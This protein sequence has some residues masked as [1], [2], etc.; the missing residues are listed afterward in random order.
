M[1][2][3]LWIIS[4]Y[5]CVLVLQLQRH[6]TEFPSHLKGWI[7]K[8][9]SFQNAEG[10]PSVWLICLSFCISLSREGK[11]TYSP[12]LWL[13]RV[14]FCCGYMASQLI[15]PRICLWWTFTHQ[16][17]CGIKEG[18]L[19]YSQIRWENDPSLTCQIGTKHPFRKLL[20]P[21]MGKVIIIIFGLKDE[22]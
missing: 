18:I 8:S 22:C 20:S 10:T 17:S 14:W 6:W 21:S 19:Y 1:T 4:G 15:P 7:I 16:S 11:V 2:T 13:G 12:S 5:P 9:C 3:W